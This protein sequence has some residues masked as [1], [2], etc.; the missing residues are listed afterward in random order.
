MVCGVAAALWRRVPHGGGL[1]GAVQSISLVSLSA[2]CRVLM[3][4][5]WAGEGCYESAS[6]LLIGF[7]E[8]NDTTIK[9]LMILSSI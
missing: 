4:T 6:R 3:A 1:L 9:E 8:L 5:S 2:R 7:G